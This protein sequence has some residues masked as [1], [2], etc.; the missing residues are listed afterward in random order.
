MTKVVVG[1]AGSEGWANH[2]PVSFQSPAHH[3]VL[4]KSNLETAI[5]HTVCATPTT[6]LSAKAKGNDAA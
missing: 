6:S 3:L 2:M 4:R 5:R 1:K